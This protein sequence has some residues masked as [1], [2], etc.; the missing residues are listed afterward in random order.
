MKMAK[1]WTECLTM[2]LSEEVDDV[3]EDDDDEVTSLDDSL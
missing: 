3:E 2:M 1:H